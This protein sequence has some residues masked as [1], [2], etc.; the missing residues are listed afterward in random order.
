ATMTDPVRGTPATA[1]VPTPFPRR[2]TTVPDAAELPTTLMVRA[3]QLL[4]AL[5]DPTYVVDVTLEDEDVDCRVVWVS[6]A[7]AAATGYP[8]A[9]LRERAPRLVTRDGGSLREALRAGV[10]VEVGRTVERSDGSEF[11]ATV[12]VSPLGEGSDGATRWLVTVR[13]ATEELASAVMA[14]ERAVTEERARR[15]LSLV[16]RVSDI[17]QDTD[18]GTELIEIAGLLVRRIVPWA[19]FYAAGT[20]LQRSTALAG[21]PYH[22]RDLRRQARLQ[23]GVPDPVRDLLLAPR[24]QTVV[25]D[26]DRPARENTL[27]AELLA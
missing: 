14:E 3:D 16:A 20:R 4:D 21:I 9:E 2:R 10:P 17:L 26:R 12:S 1:A 5:P 19:A 6:T 25:I 24:M 27:T 13:D 7:L 8:V 22:R 18:S 11:R 15:G 23:P